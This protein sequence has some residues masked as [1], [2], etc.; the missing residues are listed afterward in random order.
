MGTTGAPVAGSRG[1]RVASWPWWRRPVTAASGC[2]P[3]VVVWQCRQPPP[4]PGRGAAVPPSSDPPRVSHRYAAHVAPDATDNERIPSHPPRPVRAAVLGAS[5]GTST[6]R[7]QDQRH[8]ERTTRHTTGTDRPLLAQ[9][10]PPE[11]HG[12]RP[13]TRR[14]RPPPYPRMHPPPTRARR[15]IRRA[16]R[17]SGDRPRPSAPSQSS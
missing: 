2:V 9:N 12:K 5:G 11:Q 4:P 16:P 8:E 14:L 6:A 15:T 7:A 13:S 1:A 17:R 10:P 3:T